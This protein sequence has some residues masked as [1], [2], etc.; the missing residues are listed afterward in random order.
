VAADD[1]AA[2]R[3][4]A[5]V[6]GL[7]EAPAIARSRL[8]PRVR[9]PFWDLLEE[10]DV[11]LVVSREYEHFLLALGSEGGE[12]RITYLPLPHPSGL[13][14]DGRRRTLHVASTRNPNAIYALRPAGEPTTRPCLL[15][16]QVRFLPGSTYLH[17]LAVIDGVLHGNA[18]G[19]NAVARVDGEAAELVWWPRTVEVDG[20]PQLERNHI[21]LNAIAA[22]RS[23]AESFFTASSAAVGRRRPGHRDFPVDGRGVV[24]SGT[25]RD[26]WAGGLTRPH[27]LRFRRET[28]W[29]DTSGYGEVG[30]VGRDR[31]E[32]VA[33]LPGWTRGLAFAGD[34]VFVGTSRVIRRFS[35]Y[36][37][38]VDVD[39]ARCGIHIVSAQGTP[40]A[41][42]TWADGDQ[43]FAIEA[44]P[45]AAGVGALPFSTRRRY[46][47]EREL[48]FRFNWLS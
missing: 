29:V 46:A 6:Y 42:A 36:A 11:S 24:F 8:V 22:G 32:P 39:R 15:P 19:H 17:D 41:S 40:L 7:W 23:V 20:R 44:L 18:T 48:F 3:R 16:A 25:T 21:Q 1:H 45:R 37:P 30:V 2:W 38:G 27:S 14:W 13:A 28:L 12:P 47:R 43:I 35:A 10:A 31:Y 33:R 34:L 5:D 4:P 9:G 26:V